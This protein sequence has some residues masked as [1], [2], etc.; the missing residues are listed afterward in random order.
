[1]TPPLP[2]PGAGSEADIDL[3]LHAARQAIL[4]RIPDPDLAPQG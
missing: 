2:P 3:V 1:M 4:A